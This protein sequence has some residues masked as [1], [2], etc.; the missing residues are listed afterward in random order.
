MK[1]L[2]DTHVHSHFSLLDGV[3]SPTIIAKR[4]KELGM[5]AIALTDHGTVA[6]LF[7]F[8][9]ACKKEGIKPLLGCE[10]YFKETLQ[11]KNKDHKYY[12]CVVIAI[13]ATGFKN[14]LLL[15]SLGDKE[16]RREF[17]RPVVSFQDVIDHN[18]GLIFSTGCLDGIIGAAKGVPYA[19][20]ERHIKMFKA[21]FGNRMF[22]EIGPARINTKWEVISGE[23]EKKVKAYVPIKKTARMFGPVPYET[24][25]IQYDHNMRALHMAMNH[26]IPVILGSDA[27]MVHPDLKPV[28]DLMMK[29]SPTNSDGWHF[30]QIHAL[31]STEEIWQQF[32]SH[33]S[34]IPQAMFEEALDNCYKLAEMVE[35]FDID[36]SIKIPHFN[37]ERHPLYQEGMGARDLMMEIIKD[38]GRLPD[39]DVYY[40]R[41]LK[42]ISV[43]CDNG[44]ADYT[45]YFLILSDIARFAK[46]VN[47]GMGP[48]RGSGGGCLLSFV[49]GITSIDPI[50]HELDFARFLN[51]GRL[52]AGHP[53]DIDMDFTDR[54]PIVDYL[55]GLYGEKHMAMVGSFQ[56]TKTK[57]ALRDIVRF[58]Q[59]DGKLPNNDEIHG[60]CKTIETAPQYF[61]TE[62]D[63][64]EGFTDD[65]GVHHRGHL[66]KNKE[67]RKYLKCNAE[68][69]SPPIK[70]KELLIQLLEKPKW[71]SKHA[72][73]VV[74]T[75]TPIDCSIPTRFYQHQKCTQIDFKTVEKIGGMKID[76]LGVNT[77]NFIWG[78][79]KLIKE[80]QNV[81]LDPWNLDEKDKA[82]FKTLEMGDTATIFQFDTDVV[83]PILREMKPSSLK[84]LIL[85]TSVA[86][87][88]G[89]DSKLE[90]GVS[91]TDHFKWRKVGRESVQLLDPILE[92][93]LSE[94]FGL[95]IFQ[96]Q[97]QKIF[98]VVG[99]LTPEQSDDARRAIGKKDLQL[100]ISIKQQLF[101]NAT[102]K[103]GWTVEKCNALWE[104]FIGAS[105]YAWNK[106]HAVAY[107]KI[108]YACAYLKHNYPLEW[109]CSVLS[110]I[111]PEKVKPY[112]PI[113]GKWLRFP[114]VNCPQFGWNIITDTKGHKKLV[115]PLTLV[116]SVGNGAVLTIEEAIKT[117]GPFT[118]FKD[119]FTR[120]NK[121]RVNKTA[122]MSMIV[123]GCFNNLPLNAE[124]PE[125]VKDKPYVLI[126]YLHELRRGGKRK[127]K[128]AVPI[129]FDGL[130]DRVK[131]LMQRVHV[132]PIVSYNYVEEF[133]DVIRAIPT[134]AI[135]NERHHIGGYK[136]IENLEDLEVEQNDIVVIGLISDFSL[137]N[138]SNRDGKRLTAYKITIE[139]DRRNVKTVI[140][141]NL[142]KSDS[143]KDLKKG[144]LVAIQGR[145]KPDERFGPQIIYA[146]HILLLQG[147]SVQQE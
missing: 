137:L 45:N 35:N 93:I 38:T 68:V 95:C 9:S 143:R 102:Q 49:M 10:L 6:G 50:K 147:E 109:W 104:S 115:A 101:T 117:G 90:D 133:I 146:D 132:L 107:G 92:P 86:R 29:S 21:A 128:D 26:E 100:L 87:P 69:G 30:G 63:F 4:A 28:Q 7:E 70:T 125:K 60:L 27:H 36:F 106:A 99:G 18:E 119:F 12:H 83:R 134:H 80:I 88:S 136:I 16:G 79:I 84:D 40:K 25:C 48:A 37:L 33:H 127:T 103:L 121:T 89:F 144:N 82:T 19:T 22:V 111:E 32:Q 14:L 58:M 110:S 52:K 51:V 98:E 55:F 73:G 46:Q 42:E 5:P 20:V 96:E 85:I 11:D 131:Q 91:V 126:D 135:I 122:I 145:S 13:N 142:I 67:L 81:E 94:T 17:N 74:I 116:R 75:P 78:A 1:R 108:A 76:I 53:P 140:W 61:P 105:N 59:Y 15:S 39:K 72:G 24:D 57:A 130:N 23:G 62:R 113:V 43:I 114:N 34:D 141:P 3:S 118:S 123:A 66:E 47:I 112:L 64:L 41:L 124:N 44:V 2:I 54:G 120:V 138:Y 97:I 65:D 129:E 31:M 139:N 56:T 77:L 71:Y 8:Y